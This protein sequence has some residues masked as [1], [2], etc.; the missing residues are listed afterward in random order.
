[1][2]GLC[3][4]TS[5][6]AGDATIRTPVEVLSI[7]DVP[8]GEIDDLS[9]NGTTD[10]GV[11]PRSTS[12]GK[13]GLRGTKPVVI[14]FNALLMLCFLLSIPETNWNLEACDS[15]TSSQQLAT[16]DDVLF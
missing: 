8:L 9:S 2:R 6:M 12:G 3:G 15:H 14:F 10:R 11:R 13:M 1:M 5:A 16:V 7:C 4:S